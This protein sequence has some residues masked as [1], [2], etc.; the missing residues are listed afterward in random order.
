MAIS[1]EYLDMV[2]EGKIDVVRGRLAGIGDDGAL[3]VSDGERST[4]LGDVGHVICCTGYLPRLHDFLSADILSTVDYNSSDCFSPK[5]L[6]W[7]TIHPSLP[8]LAFCGMYRGPYMGV[9]ELQARL[10]AGVLGGSLDIGADQLE[11]A[12]EH[13]RIRRSHVPRAQFPHFDY[14]GF[15]DMLSQLCSGGEY[16]KYNTDTRDMVAPGFYQ[17][18]EEIARKCGSEIRH[19]IQLGQDGSRVPEVVLQSILGKWSYDRIIVHQQTNKVERVFGTVKYSKYW[20]RS[21][22]SD[23]GDGNGEGDDRF[24][25]ATASNPILYREDGVYEFSPTQRFDVF[26]EYE[27]ECKHDALEIYFVEGGKRAHL[28][29]SLKFVPETISDRV[30]SSD[31]GYWVKATSDHLCI[32]DLYSATF[33]VKLNGMSA[34][35]IVIKYRVKGPAKDYE[36][37]TILKPDWS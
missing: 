7:D 37:T 32:K 28:F 30:A 13:S 20:E 34:S 19:E 35:E 15:M 14:V 18:D 11:M 12:L 36:S 3:D 31:C 21:A 27:Y 25:D 4:T 10:A 1:D 22:P 24:S 2:R 33:R 23:D 5:T 16:P 26:R 6:A 17:P 8:G 29:L 9:M